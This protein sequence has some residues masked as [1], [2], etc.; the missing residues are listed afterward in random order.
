MVSLIKYS[1]NEMKSKNILVSCLTIVSLL[2]LASIASVSLISA[3]SSLGTIN[4]VTVDDLSV[5]GNDL[6][7]VAGDTVSLQVFFT[8]DVNA[9]DITVEATFETDKEDVKSE[10]KS[11]DI[12]SGKQ[13]VKRLSLEV[14]F[15]LKDELSNDMNLNIEISGDGYKEEMDYTLRV[16]RDSYNSEIKSVVVSQTVEAG[17]TFPVDIVLKN[18]GYNNLDDVYVTA[19]ISALGVEKTAYFGDLVAIECDKDLSSEENYGVD[20]DR[21]CNEDDK[22]TVTGRIYLDTPYEAKSGIY[23]LEVEVTNDDV[24]KKE[25]IQ[26]VVNN[27][28]ADNVII[29]STTQKVAVGDEADYKLLIVNPTNKLKVYRVVT[30]TSEG[31]SSSADESVVAVPAGSSKQVVVTAKALSE[32]K[33]D[34]NVNVFSGDEL[35]SSAVLTADAEGS[36]VSTTSPV[37]ILTVVLAII[38]IVLLIV[39]IV[40]ITKKPEKS[41]EFGESYY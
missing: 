20:V 1:K 24:T 12:E 36:S 18:M 25:V 26:L 33:H 16:Q 6:S 35:V 30:E 31:L 15:D 10:T 22:D 34:F 41:E 14:P 27:D 37:T 29:A 5:T 28:F 3:T 19:R 40:L 7:V 9:S 39:L 21:K 4:E 11:F 13:Y 8:S 23:A 2:I 32:G 38:F 17:E